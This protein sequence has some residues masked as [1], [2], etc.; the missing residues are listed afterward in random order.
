[1]KSVQSFGHGGTIFCSKVGCASSTGRTWYFPWAKQTK[2]Q[3]TS[4]S[5][6]TPLGKLEVLK[7][8]LTKQAQAIQFLQEATRKTESHQTKPKLDRGK[9]PNPPPPVASFPGGPPQGSAR[10]VGAPAPPLPAG[11]WP[12]RRH[13]GL[14][15]RKPPAG[16]GAPAGSRYVGWSLGMTLLDGN[17]PRDPTGNPHFLHFSFPIG[18]W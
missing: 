16:F 9:P 17:E 5:S 11:P 14:R 6:G 15:R 1:M 13:G 3:T 8:K 4:S 10:R 2:K 18:G 12:R 7:A